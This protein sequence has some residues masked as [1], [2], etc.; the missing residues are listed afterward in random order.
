MNYV[1]TVKYHQLWTVNCNI[2]IFSELRDN[3]G[4]SEFLYEG[5]CYKIVIGERMFHE[6]LDYCDSIGGHLMS[7]SNPEEWTFIAHLLKNNRY[8]GE[9]DTFR[10][11]AA[12]IYGS[13]V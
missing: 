2:P 4:P 8:C 9:Y 1:F 12:N 13:K 5:K 11:G 10:I 6:A 3:C 7:V